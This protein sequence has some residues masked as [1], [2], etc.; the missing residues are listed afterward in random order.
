MSLRS[1]TITLPVNRKTAEV[2]EA[3][4]NIPPK[5]VPDAKKVDDWWSFTTEHGPTKLK[6][7][8]NKELG[9]LDHQLVENNYTWYVP[10]RVVSQGNK[11]AIIMTLFQPIHYTD[12]T[13]DERMKELEKIMQQM[14]QIIEQ[15]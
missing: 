4:L 5:I 12:Q 1:H 10:M 11:S 8:A 7:I 13:F 3:I 14:K 6:F 2:F 15:N 9:I